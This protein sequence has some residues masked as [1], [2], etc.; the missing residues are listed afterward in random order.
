MIRCSSYRCLRA[1][2]SFFARLSFFVWVMS[3]I[4]DDTSLVTMILVVGVGLY[5]VCS[6]WLEMVNGFSGSYIL[7]FTVCFGLGTT[8]HSMPFVHLLIACM[9]IGALLILFLCIDNMVH[10]FM[11]SY[12]LLFV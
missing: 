8:L 11:V 9:K 6:F 2:L 5:L 3:V 10:M 4:C 1:A 12:C 7:F